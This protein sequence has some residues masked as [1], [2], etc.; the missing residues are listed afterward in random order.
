MNHQPIPESRG[1]PTSGSYISAALP[2]VVAQSGPAGTV[3]RGLVITD[4]PLSSYI[5][6]GGVPPVATGHGWYWTSDLSQAVQSQFM[7]F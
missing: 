4:P 7:P 3:T 1:E 5:S 2:A 6:A